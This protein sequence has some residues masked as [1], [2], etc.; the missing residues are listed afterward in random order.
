MKGKWCDIV[1]P[2]DDS[3]MLLYSLSE[4]F[5]LNPGFAYLVDT[6][7]L[8]NMKLVAVD[9]S[10]EHQYSWFVPFTALMSVF[11]YTCKQRKY[12]FEQRLGHF[13]A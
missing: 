11:L 8:R 5:A 7:Y 12:I 1:F 13:A 6:N 3:R 2:M 4:Y 9:Y 10:V